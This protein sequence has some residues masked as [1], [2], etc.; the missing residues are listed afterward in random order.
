[1]KFVAFV[2]AL[3]LSLGARLEEALAWGR[4]GHAIVADV[5]EAQLSPRAQA[6]VRRLLAPEGAMH[7]SEV[8]SWAD[9]KKAEG[10]PGTPSHS[11]RLPIGNDP[12]RANACP[13]RFCIVAAINQYTSVLSD[14]SQ[15]ASSRQEALKYLV[16]LV[17]DVHQ[18][19]HTIVA[20][21]SRYE[22]VFDGK[23]TNLHKVWDTGIIRHHHGRPPE[24]AQELLRLQ[25]DFNLGGDALSWAVEGRDIARDTIYRQ[26]PLEPEGVVTLSPD[27][28]DQNW[29]I[30]ARRLTQAGGRLAHLLNKAFE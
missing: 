17:G 25:G 19:L 16:H 4:E 13:S 29:P 11:L 6:E 22:V 12:F 14:R 21:G 10:G 26:I 30:V 15:S 3:L 18:P 23:L 27:Y 8:A 20:T 9:E 2:L 28:A 7:L 24:I 5:A 1:M